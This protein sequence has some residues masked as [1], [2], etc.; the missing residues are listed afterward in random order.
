[1]RADRD[2]EAFARRAHKYESG[3]LGRMH[4]QIALRSVELVLKSGP[5]PK[6]I[7]DVGCGTGYLLREL[8]QRCPEAVE[9]TGVDPANEMI[10]AAVA[11]SATTKVNFLEGVAAE[12]LPFEDAAFDVVTATNSFDHWSDQRLGMRECHRVLVPGGRLVLV[13]LFTPILAPTLVASHRGKARTK[14]RVNALLANAGFE[15]PD[16]Q[17]LYANVIKAVVAQRPVA[18]GA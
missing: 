12:H 7:L 13:D 5:P 17:T 11:A 14:R 4:K 15:D 6:R 18:P 9:L 1:M 16:W 8:E 10:R 3:V 2:V